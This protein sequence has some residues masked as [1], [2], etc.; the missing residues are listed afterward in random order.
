MENQVIRRDIGQFNEN[1]K[2]M[3]SSTVVLL[4]TVLF[5]VL[6]IIVWFFVG[7]VTDK[8]TL[9]GVVLSTG[10]TTDVCIP[11][12]GVVRSVFIRE[13][14]IVKAGQHIA[15]VSVGD[16]YSVVTSTSDGIV[17]SSKQN[18]DTFEAFEPVATLSTDGGEGSGLMLLAFSD[19]DN[20][21]NL[22]HGQPVQVWP[23]NEDK[24]EVGFVRGSIGSV[25]ML[26][27]DRDQVAKIIKIPAYLDALIP[28]K[29]IS[30]EVHVNLDEAKDHPGTLDW[31]FDKRVHPDMSIGTLC[32]AI[33]IT[34]E[35][36]IFEY[37]F[38]RSKTTGNKVKSWL[39]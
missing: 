16:S 4:C 18:N 28:D 29:I 26:P 12:A 35:Y 30:Y 38:L 2:V 34:R 33:V 11:Q 39:N 27:V 5:L 10:G 7:T 14:Q 20:I 9:K 24:D 36:T 37:L 15:M 3:S 8:A 19:L 32:D 1:I 13:G 31:T 25:S 22:D 17:L 23:S 21:K 6:S